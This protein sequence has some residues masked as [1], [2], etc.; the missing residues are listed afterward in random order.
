MK[1]TPY[2][3]LNE[4]DKR[5]CRIEEKVDTLIEANKQLKQ[6]LAETLLRLPPVPDLSASSLIEQE[7]QAQRLAQLENDLQALYAFAA[8]HNLSDLTALTER[9]AV[10]ARAV[11]DGYEKSHLTIKKIKL[12]D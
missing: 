2:W 3:Q 1:K 11:A 6:Q 9:V 4:S 5:T 8:V 10:S 7:Q 12:N